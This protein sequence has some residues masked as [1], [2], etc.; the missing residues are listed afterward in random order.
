V[1]V[2]YFDVTLNFVPNPDSFT[3]RLKER[4]NDANREFIS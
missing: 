1:Y 2:P 4:E 3:L